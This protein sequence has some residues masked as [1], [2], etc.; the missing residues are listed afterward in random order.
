MFHFLQS[1][2]T[3]DYHACWWIKSVIDERIEARLGGKLVPVAAACFQ[4]CHAS[5][6]IVFVFLD[7]GRNIRAH[8]ARVALSVWLFFCPPHSISS[9][10]LSCWLWDRRRRCKLNRFDV[11]DVHGS[12]ET[13]FA[14]LFASGCRRIK[15]YTCKFTQ[16]LVSVLASHPTVVL[17]VSDVCIVLHCCYGTVAKDINQPINHLIK[18]PSLSIGASLQST[19]LLYQTMVHSF[20]FNSYNDTIS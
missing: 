15:R 16:L 2:R 17:F 13:L 12:R 1:R 19:S 3:S 6:L 11:L 9:F 18:M 8:Y 10:W 14:G 4:N 5:P 20:F 7:H